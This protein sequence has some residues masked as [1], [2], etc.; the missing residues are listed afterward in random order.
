MTLYRMSVH[1]EHAG[2]FQEKITYSWGVNPT[3]L[4]LKYVL[5]DKL[6]KSTEQC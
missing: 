1:K 2:N 5:P 6:I 4:S 3:T